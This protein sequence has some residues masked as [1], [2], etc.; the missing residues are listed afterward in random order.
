MK[1]SAVNKR[2]SPALLLVFGFL[3]WILGMAGCPNA[4]LEVA[5]KSS[6]EALLY[7]A[8]RNI[9]SGNY[10]TA[11]NV[12]QGITGAATQTRDY[13]IISASAYAG[14]CGLNL[15]QTAEALVD[16]VAANQKLFQA[17]LSHFKTAGATAANNCITAENL[18][19]TLPLAQWESDEY[20]FYAF[21]QFA[22]IGTIVA[23]SGADTNNDGTVD[24]A[25]NACTNN[26]SHIVDADVQHL[27]SGLTQAIWAL[28][29]AVGGAAVDALN[30]AVSACTVI[31][32]YIPNFCDQLDESDFT[33]AE[34]VAIRQLLLSNEV[35]LN[36][37][38]N[39][40]M[41]GA[42]CQ[43]N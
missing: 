41:S 21:L 6:T 26:A 43:C 3:P 13:K 4:F 31:E 7:S 11:L 14:K 35:G 17:L 40:Y 18:M 10:D 30:A 20:V 28:Q 29:A 33:G 37:C 27:A 2:K 36:I 39:T 32:G 25:F 9:D 22:K 24:P 42:S 15:V 8:K 23:R 19:K 5:D 34:I 12:L 16:S 38:G 1:E